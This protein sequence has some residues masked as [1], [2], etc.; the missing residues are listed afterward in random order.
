MNSNLLQPDQKEKKSNFFLFRRVFGS[1]GMFRG[2]LNRLRSRNAHENNR[3]YYLNSQSLDYCIESSFQCDFS[4]E[5]T[6]SR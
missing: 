4:T 1:H 3:V 2:G 5:Y 6:E